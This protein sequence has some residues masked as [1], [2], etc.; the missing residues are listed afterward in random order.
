VPITERESLNWQAVKSFFPNLNV[1]TFLRPL[2]DHRVIYV[3]N[4]KAGCS[5]IL[6]WLDRIHTG[7]LDTQFTNVH[8]EHRLPTV[9][10]VGRETV[11]RML[12]GDA[13]R[14]TFVRNPLDRFESTY[15]DKIVHNV[16][17]NV[18][19]T[20]GLDPDSLPIPFE[21]FLSRVEDHDPATLEPHSRPQHLNLM[22]PLV[23]YDHIGKLETFAADLDI[24][25]D[26][27]G[28][29]GAPYELRN[30]SKHTGNSVYDGRPDLVRRVEQL[31]ATDFEI[32]GY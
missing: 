7:Q 21:Q 30:P 10:D 25:R 31:Y 4:A 16:A 18:I 17:P 23:G 15:W 14:F 9:A 22:H 27:A 2:P 11:L 12:A 24:I 32:Y 5:T 26:T 1:S 28:L 8:R 13:Y 29:P 3:K 6:V 20:L 19:K